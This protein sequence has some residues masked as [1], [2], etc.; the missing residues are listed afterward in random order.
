MRGTPRDH[1]TARKLARSPARKS[2]FETQSVQDVRLNSVKM[3]I[4]S[5]YC[6]TRRDNFETSR[7]VAIARSRVSVPLQRAD[8]QVLWKLQRQTT[9][10]GTSILRLNSLPPPRRCKDYAIPFDG[11]HYICLGFCPRSM[12]FDRR[13]SA[14][15]H[16]FVSIV[17]FCSQR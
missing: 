9:R 16:R 2:V 10:V 17:F 12:S 5:R 13:E 3:W 6:F 11:R 7:A 15:R 1:K 8:G 14:F 4:R